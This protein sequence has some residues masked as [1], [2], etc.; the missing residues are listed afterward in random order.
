MGDT[1]PVSYAQCPIRRIGHAYKGDFDSQ[2]SSEQT[3]LCF[4]IYIPL[5]VD[6]FLGF[7]ISG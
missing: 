4:E 7:K 2:T 3:V 6:N 5:I 1:I